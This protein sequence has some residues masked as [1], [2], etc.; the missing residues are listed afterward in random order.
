MEPSL[1]TSSPQAPPC[2]VIPLGTPPCQSTPVP[3]APEGT[4]LP[5]NGGNKET[6]LSSGCSSTPKMLFWGLFYVPVTPQHC[7]LPC[8][9]LSQ[10]PPA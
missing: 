3:A 6:L 10:L 4:D 5:L 2:S 1:S 9:T 7:Q 8:P